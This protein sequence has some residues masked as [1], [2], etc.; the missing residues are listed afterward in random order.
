M[1]DPT[2]DA[3]TSG[4]PAFEE[5]NAP[6][7]M[8][9]IGKHLWAAELHARTTVP[10]FESAG[11]DKTSYPT[12]AGMAGSGKTTLMQR[13]HNYFHVEKLPSYILNLDPAVHQVPYEPNIDIRDTVGV[14]LLASGAS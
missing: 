4:R 9:V 5:G 6:L 10:H 1:A 14:L 11:L 13:L 8:L 7:V 3:S 12:I 2:A